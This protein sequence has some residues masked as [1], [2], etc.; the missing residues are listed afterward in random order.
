[1]G[2]L[3]QADKQDA[4]IKIKQYN[5]QALNAYNLFLSYTKSI[6]DLLELMKTNEDYIQSDC[7]EVQVLVTKLEALKK[8]INTK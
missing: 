8:E 2:F 7:D 3:N 1:M 6:A 4:A 5:E